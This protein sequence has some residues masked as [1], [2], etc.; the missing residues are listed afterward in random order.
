M[1]SAKEIWFG[2]WRRYRPASEL[3]PRLILDRS[4]KLAPN[5]K[6]K[7]SAGNTNALM[8]HIT[9]KEKALARLLEDH[10]GLGYADLDISEEADFVM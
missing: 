9:A 8:A 3:L 1:T 2:S 4:N 10:P 5:A 7:L 6:N